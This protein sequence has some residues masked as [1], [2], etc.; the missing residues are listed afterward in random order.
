MTERILYRH[1]DAPRRAA[2]LQF[3]ESDGT[4]EQA[5][6]VR[7]DALTAWL[8]DNAPA[9][10]DEKEQM[11]STAREQ[12]YWRHGYLVALCSIRAFIAERRRAMN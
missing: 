9:T 10:E 2:T 1:A 7:I 5:L 12:L 11:A 6:D 8:G 3:D 4:L